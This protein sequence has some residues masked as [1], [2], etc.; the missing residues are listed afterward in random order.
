MYFL[1]RVGVNTGIELKDNKVLV[2][3]MFDILSI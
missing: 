2:V 1:L 3:Y